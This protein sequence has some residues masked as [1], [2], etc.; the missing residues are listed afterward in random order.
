MNSDLVRI[1]EKSA[2]LGSP[3]SN[4]SHLN[5]GPMSPN[6]RKKRTEIISDLLSYASYCNM[7]YLSTSSVL[8]DSDTKIPAVSYKFPSMYNKTFSSSHGLHRKSPVHTC[9][10]KAWKFIHSTESP[11]K[12]QPYPNICVIFKI[13]LLLVEIPNIKRGSLGGVW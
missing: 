13:S 4:H 5:C 7:Q 12:T 10:L 1:R 9:R 3:V 11:L 6:N 8:H 2:T